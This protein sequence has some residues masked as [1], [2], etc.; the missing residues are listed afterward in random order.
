M[1]INKYLI[2]ARLKQAMAN[3]KA[4][5]IIVY[6]RRHCGKSILLRE[7]LPQNAIINY[8]TVWLDYL[9]FLK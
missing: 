4:R 2:K 7:A 1:F 8:F 5:L 6:G 9:T 3:K